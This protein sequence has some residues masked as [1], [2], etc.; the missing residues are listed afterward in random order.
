MSHSNIDNKLNDKTNQ[1][2]TN[3]GNIDKKNSQTRTKSKK[4]EK[5]KK[6]KNNSGEVV[7]RS[8]TKTNN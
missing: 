7:L 3:K 6:A 4:A 1:E 2:I 8:L 5:A